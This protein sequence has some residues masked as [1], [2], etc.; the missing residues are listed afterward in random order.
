[1]VATTNKDAN[2]STPSI[3]K[4]KDHTVSPSGSQCG[5][6]TSQSDDSTPLP[7]VRQHLQSQGISSSASDIIMQSWRT[8]TRVQCSSYIKKWL[9]YCRKWQINPV[10]PPVA[11]GLNFLA[12]LYHKEHSCSALNTARSALA[13][14]IVLQG[15]QSF[16]K[17]TF[18]TRPALP[19]YKEVWDVNTVLEHL[20]TLHTA[21][22]LSLTLLSLK[23][24]M[25]MAM[26]LVFT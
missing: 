1:M 22:T 6:P 7:L 2:T 24:G 17:G 4:K 25:L 14:V 3:T 23:L 15:N 18:A 13:S 9:E 5:A 8:S 21:E 16:S 20:K 12:E 11:S 19:K 10:S 26:L